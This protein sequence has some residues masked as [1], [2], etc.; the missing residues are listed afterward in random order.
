MS[1]ETNYIPASFVEIWIVLL[2]LKD[3]PASYPQKKDCFFIS[4]TPT[5]CFVFNKTQTRLTDAV[6]NNPFVVNDIPASN[7]KTSFS[8]AIQ[9]APETPRPA[10]GESG[11]SPLLIFGLSTH[12]THCADRTHPEAPMHKLRHFLAIYHTIC[13]LSSKNQGALRSPQKYFRISE[14]VMGLG[15]L[16]DGS[17]GSLSTGAPSRGLG[18]PNVP[19]K[20]LKELVDDLPSGAQ[21]QAL[22]HAGDYAADLGFSGVLDDGL[23]RGVINKREGSLAFQKPAG[24]LPFHFHS[25]V[26]R[27]DRVQN[28]DASVVRALDRGKADF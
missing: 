24:S 8:R 12:T 7:R 19:G 2:I 23:S 1:F 27:R 28:F 20:S 22:A 10:A 11:R 5:R 6:S 16:G 17:W 18:R 13:Y 9:R 21:H 15:I 4:R 3:I 14:Y 26:F 25:K